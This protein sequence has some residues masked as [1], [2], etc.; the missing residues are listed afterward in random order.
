MRFPVS[1]TLRAA[2]AASTLLLA[3]SAQGQTVPQAPPARNAD[4]EAAVATQPARDSNAPQRAYGVLP[5]YRFAEGQAQFQ[6]LT[7]GQKFHIAW[8]DSTDWP[9][10]PTTLMFTGIY[11]LENQN[12]SFGQGA[13]G[14]AHRFGTAYADQVI[15]NYF[16]EAIVPVVAHQDPRYFR[17]GH[18]SALVR[19]AYAVSRLFLAKSDSGHMTLNYGELGGNV[20]Q[21]AIAN[22]YYPDTRTITQNYQRMILQLCTD[23]ISQMLKEFWP[24]VR[25][26]FRRRRDPSGL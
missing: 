21:I 9:V 6:P 1:E 24:D 4:A 18:G 23:G 3:A 22:S 16:M 2:T 10:I 15:G 7:A 12:P 11:H 8:K 13:A 19:A 26:H 20:I 14:F 5:N 25:N 17:L